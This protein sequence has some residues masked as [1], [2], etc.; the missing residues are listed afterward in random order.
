[1]IKCIPLHDLKH[2]AGSRR[3]VTVESRYSQH[4]QVNREQIEDLRIKQRDQR[5]VHF[6]VESSGWVQNKI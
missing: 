3:D 4:K 5:G 2:L 1:M 6:F